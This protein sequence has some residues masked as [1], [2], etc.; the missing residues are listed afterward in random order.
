[1]RARIRSSTKALLF[2]GPSVQPGGNHGRAWTDARRQLLSVPKPGAVI[3][4]GPGNL[5]ENMA[6]G[7]VL[8]PGRATPYRATPGNSSRSVPL[9]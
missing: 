7:G 5:S 3:A 1:M 4:G 2:A 6:I 9:L 8:R